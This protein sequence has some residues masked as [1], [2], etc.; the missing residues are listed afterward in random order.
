MGLGFSKG[1]YKVHDNTSMCFY[2][3][4]KGNNFRDFLFAIV[5]WD[6]F[7]RERICHKRNDLF[8][9]RVDTL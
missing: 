6:L 7:L 1:I 9:V 8:S 3:F 2:H 4:T 5:K